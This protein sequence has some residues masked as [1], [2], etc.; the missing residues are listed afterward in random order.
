[1]E[2]KRLLEE[3]R[4]SDLRR[5]GAGRFET[6]YKLLLQRIKNYDPDGEKAHAIAEEI[7]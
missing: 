1:M 2:R 4:V 7:D 6:Y 5:Y 3:L